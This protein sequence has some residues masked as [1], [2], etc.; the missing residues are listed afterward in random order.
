MFGLP[1]YETGKEN[2]GLYYHIP[3]VGCRYFMFLKIKLFG[4]RLENMNRKIP[5]RFLKRLK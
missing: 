5:T 2:S 3:E 4:V 1:F